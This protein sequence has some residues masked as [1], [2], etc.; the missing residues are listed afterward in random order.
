MVAAI[1]VALDP[2]PKK[3]GI[4]TWE[5]LQM[6]VPVVTKLGSGPAERVGGAIVTAVGLDEWVAENDE[7]YLAI[8]LKFCFRPAGLAPL[9]AMLPAL[10]FQ[11]AAGDGALFTHHVEEGYR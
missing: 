2:F 11:S 5:S 10:V 8:A 9:R 6:G 1:D 3:G 7:G 4:S